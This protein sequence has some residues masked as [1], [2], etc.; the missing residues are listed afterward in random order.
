M[1][2]FS[3]FTGKGGSGIIRGEQVAERMGAKLN[4]TEDY[5]DDVCIYVKRVPPDDHPSRAWL[6]I[7]D[8]SHDLYWLNKHPEVGIIATCVA[9]EK[10]LWARYPGRDIVLVPE[11]HCNFDRE[12][13]TRVSVERVGVIGHPKSIE[14]DADELAGKLKD[15]G[16]EFV[17]LL[18]RNISSRQMVVDFYKG[19]DLQ[20]IWRPRFGPE[21]SSQHERNLHN[22]LKLI[23]AMSFGVP[24][25]AYPELNFE[26][27]LHNFYVPANDV[28][29]LLM[30]LEQMKTD[31]SVYQ[32]ISER[33]LEKS[34][35]YHIDNILPRYL[36]L[37][38]EATLN[39]S[40]SGKLL[41]KFVIVDGKPLRVYGLQS[42]RVKPKR[43]GL[44]SYALW[45]L[46]AIA[47]RAGRPIIAFCDDNVL[48][49]YL[50]CGWYELGMFQDHHIISNE[51]FDNI[52][53]K[54]LW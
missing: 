11:H 39:C 23:N 28:D 51:L 46:E 10:Y 8:D 50:K 29:E 32:V 31:G 7:V 49:F 16:L 34:E 3:F 38:R 33:G 40:M 41:D 45:G 26:E 4:P 22:P 13:R 5:Q 9:A 2:N 20:L 6:D 21:G 27:E 14:I 53:V 25:V 1:A 47:D 19:I 36:L 43:M 48:P 44:G 37:D 42:Y 30:R 12:V 35:D 15:I 52:V 54:E 17:P 24:T 18:D